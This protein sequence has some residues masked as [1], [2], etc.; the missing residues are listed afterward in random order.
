MCVKIFF[1]LNIFLIK[2]NKNYFY[3]DFLFLLCGGCQ[4]VAKVFLMIIDVLLFG[5]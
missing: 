2:C 5:C 1:D 3:T 4:E